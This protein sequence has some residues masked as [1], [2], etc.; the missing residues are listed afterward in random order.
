MDYVIGVRYM[1]Y[2]T[3][4]CVTTRVYYVI[5]VYTMLRCNIQEWICEKWYLLNK[6]QEMLIP[7]FSGG[8]IRVNTMLRCKIL[9]WLGEYRYLMKKE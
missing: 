4:D 3:Q 8:V 9:E 6:E 1:D 5:K 2:D 7:T